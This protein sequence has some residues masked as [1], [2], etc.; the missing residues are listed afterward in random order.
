MLKA[1][2]ISDAASMPLHWIYDQ[3]VIADK[4]ASQSEA[5]AAF[6]PTPSCPFYKYPAGVLSPY[7]DES[8][9][10]IHSIANQGDFVR[11]HAAHTMFDFFAKYPTVEG[12]SKGYEGRLNHAPKSFLAARQE[13]KEWAD[14]SQDDSQANGLAKVPIIIARYAGASKEVIDEKVASMVGILQTPEV[15]QQTALLL[16]RLLNTIIVNSASNPISSPRQAIIYVKDNAS[17]HGL[18]GY[19]QNIL[20][21]LL[22][23]EKIKQ[24]TS[25]SAA[26]QAA[27][28]DPNDGHRLMRVRGPIFS[29]YIELSMDLEEAIR[30]SGLNDADT[31]FVQEHGSPDLRTAEVAPSDVLTVALLIGLNCHLPCKCLAAH[32]FSRG[33]FNPTSVS[34]IC[35]YFQFRLQ[36]LWSWLCTSLST[37]RILL[38]QLTSTSRLAETLAPGAWSSEPCT[39]P[40]QM[41][42]SLSTGSAVSTRT[43]GGSSPAPQTK[44]LRTTR[45]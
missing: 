17:A 24:W 27:P 7:G 35:F 11:E 2:F 21:F 32:L 42:Q 29:K 19:Q 37:R 22:D 9:P 15:C 34:I 25:F 14:C 6:F 23:E 13:G 3:S 31:A 8:L 26:L 44:S 45:T 33:F 39:A 38:R 20:D 30:A 12:E 43:Y 28:A 40:C 10:L 16:A 36:V 41:S 1:S 4:L 5:S 18:S